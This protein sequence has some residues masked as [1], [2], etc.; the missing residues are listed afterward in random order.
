MALKAVG[1]P[2]SAAARILGIS[3]SSLRKMR[4]AGRGPRYFR[5][6]AKLYR[7]RLDWLEQWMN[8]QAR[9]QSAERVSVSNTPESV[10]PAEVTAK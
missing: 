6:G 3:G 10:K 8:A 1:I 5:A 7:Y 9:A 2:E 4:T